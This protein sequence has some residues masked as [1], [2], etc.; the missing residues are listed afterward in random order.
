M[1]FN[2]SDNLKRMEEIRSLLDDPKTDLD[3]SLKLYEEGI[4]LYR[5]MKTYLEDIDEKFKKI[6]EELEETHEEEN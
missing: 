2:Y 1:N 3:Q 4:G 5:E 6:N